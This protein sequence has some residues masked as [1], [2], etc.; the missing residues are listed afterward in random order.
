M[1]LLPKSA[2]PPPP[3]RNVIQALING[4]TPLLA[5]TSDTFIIP[6]HPIASALSPV[7]VRAR[8]ANNECGVLCFVPSPCLAW[9]FPFGRGVLAE[10]PAMDSSAIVC[11]RRQG[12][13]Q[14]QQPRDLHVPDQ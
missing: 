6:D 2:L 7:N 1:S 3:E 5:G 8:E 14:L 4:S 13:P 12:A 10:W 11:R 9:T